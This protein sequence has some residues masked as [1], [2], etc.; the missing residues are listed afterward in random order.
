M[1]YFYSCDVEVRG[2]QSIKIDGFKPM[3]RR[4]ETIE[5]V[6]RTEEFIKQ[7]IFEELF[8]QGKILRREDIDHMSIHYNAFNPL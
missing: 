3:N 2:G 8:R 4:I 7:D 5:D 1:V 6:K